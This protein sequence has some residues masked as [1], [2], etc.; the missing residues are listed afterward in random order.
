MVDATVVTESAPFHVDAHFAV[1]VNLVE[2]GDVG[3]LL[4][5]A[6]VRSRPRNEADLTGVILKRAG[7]QRAHRIVHNGHDLAVN[8]A[9]SGKG[10]LQQFD[11][12]MPLNVRRAK[13]LCPRNQRRRVDRMLRTRKASREVAKICN[14][15]KV[16]QK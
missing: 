12:V 10:F 5:V 14:S 11:D 7:H 9:S 4:H 6:S 1:G 13:A 16:P 15:E 3:L 8:V 2:L